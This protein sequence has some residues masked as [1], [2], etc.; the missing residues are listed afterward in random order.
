KIGNN[1]V[2]DPSSKL[3]GGGDV[4]PIVAQYPQHKITSDFKFATLFPFVRT[5][6]P[7]SSESSNIESIAATSE[8]SWAETNL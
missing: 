6:E 4:A 8:Y 7:A 1:I 3:V 2:I 5:V